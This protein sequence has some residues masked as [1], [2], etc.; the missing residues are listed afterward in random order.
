MD[1]HGAEMKSNLM[2]AILFMQAKMGGRKRWGEEDGVCGGRGRRKDASRRPVEG[3]TM[4]KK[5]KKK[6]K[7]EV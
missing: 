1:R 2:R 6:T 5:N 3:S 7:E 4:M